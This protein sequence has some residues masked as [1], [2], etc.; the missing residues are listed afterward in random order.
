METNIESIRDDSS[1]GIHEIKII[2]ASDEIVITHNA[3][4]RKIFAEG[5]IQAIEWVSCQKPGLYTMQEI[6]F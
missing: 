5:A 1:V 3:N 6:S 2:F 4:N